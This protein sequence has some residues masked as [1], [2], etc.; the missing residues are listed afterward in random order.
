MN[1]PRR[2]DSLDQL[3]ADFQ[4]R[5]DAVDDPA[6][7]ADLRV[8]KANA[9]V[10]FRQQEAEV[11]ELAAYKQLALTEFP[12]VKGFEDLVTGSNEAEIM[13]SARLVAERLSAVGQ[14]D[15]SAFED[16]RD[17]VNDVRGNPYGA[18]GVRGGGSQ[19]G[20]AYVSPDQADAR[21]E[22]N[23]ARQFNDAPRDAYGQRM[24]ISPRDVDRYAQQRFTNHIR[25]QVGFWAELTNS[26]YRGRRR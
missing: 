4:R 1:Q 7:K 23:F 6:E 12:I 14:K 8:E 25:D 10:Q 13:D 15:A 18:A 22:Q 16:F 24:G 17:R 19:P 11:R 5:I 21:W 2:Y 3:E 9:Q 20:S 26:S